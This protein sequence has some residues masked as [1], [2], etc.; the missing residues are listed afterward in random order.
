MPSLQ[1]KGFVAPDQART[2][3]HGK[4]EVVQLGE[5]AVGR[6]FFEPG[7]RWSNDVGPIVGTRSCQH[8]HLGYTISGSLHV[9][10]DD[11]T[12]L[13]ILPGNADEIPTCHESWGC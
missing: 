13:T 1:R 3:P 6:F 4:V 8:R 11:G 7:W 12:E 2:F 9:R 10:L 5:I